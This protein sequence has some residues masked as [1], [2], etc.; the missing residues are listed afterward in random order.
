MFGCKTQTNTFE[1][2]KNTF[3]RIKEIF[4]C[5]SFLHSEGDGEQS[6][7]QLNGILSV[8]TKKS[9]ELEKF[10]KIYLKTRTKIHFRLKKINRTVNEKRATFC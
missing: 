1:K 4:V 6:R 8:A 3:Q 7:V 10:K 5:V 2:W 9:T